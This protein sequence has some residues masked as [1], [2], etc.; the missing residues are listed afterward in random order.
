MA[1]CQH[2]KLSIHPLE[3][4]EVHGDYF[5]YCIECKAHLPLAQVRAILD[6]TNPPAEEGL[7][8]LLQ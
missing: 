4:H 3:D 5:Y 6:F 1:A 8:G 2:P 7:K